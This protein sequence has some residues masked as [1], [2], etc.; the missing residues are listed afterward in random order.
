MKLLKALPFFILFLLL[1]PLAYSDDATQLT[2]QRQLFQQAKKALQDNQ[3]PRYQAL[4]KQLDGYPLQGYLQYLYLN[5]R[6]NQAS[7][8]S[9]HEFLTKEDGSFYAERLR[10]FCIVFQSTFGNLSS[11]LNCPAP[12]NHSPPSM[13]TTSPLI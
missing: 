9:M 1:S 10:N 7:N 8:A 3:I 2:K 4:Y 6:L 11:S 12:F 5:G 13:V